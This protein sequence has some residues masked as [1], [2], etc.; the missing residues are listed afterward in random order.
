VKVMV[1]E[2]SPG[3]P[4]RWPVLVAEGVAADHDRL[5]PAGHQAGDVGDHDRLAEDDPTEDVADRPVRRA[6][7][8]LQAELLDPRLVRV[9]VAHLT[10]TP[11]SLIALAASTR[12]LVL[13]LV[14]LLDPRS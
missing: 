5:G 10:P 8:L 1:S 12:D 3:P 7:H 11:N 4:G 2:P 13:R 6:V 14:A 9:I